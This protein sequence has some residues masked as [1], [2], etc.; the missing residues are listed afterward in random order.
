MKTIATETTPRIARAMAPLIIMLKPPRIVIPN[1]IL[2]RT[3][4][5]GSV[6]TVGVETVG[7]VRFAPQRLQ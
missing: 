2:G 3:N 6:I 5:G 4:F 7:W 1:T